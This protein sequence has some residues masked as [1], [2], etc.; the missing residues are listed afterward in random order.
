MKTINFDVLCMM[1]KNDT[2][3]LLPFGNSELWFLRYSNVP[4]LLG[5]AAEG[6]GS[7]YKRQVFGIF[8]KYGVLSFNGNKTIV[9]GAVAVYLLL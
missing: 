8:G 7:K 2:F 3:T 6:F 4:E 9:T 1:W 5:D